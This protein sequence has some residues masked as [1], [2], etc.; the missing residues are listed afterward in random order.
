MREIN[1]EY[2]TLSTR[3]RS[4]LVRVGFN[5]TDLN[6]MNRL[7]KKLSQFVA[8][9]SGEGEVEVEAKNNDREQMNLL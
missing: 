2:E 3:A 4:I 8:V 9:C 5:K 6:T 7:S 1:Q